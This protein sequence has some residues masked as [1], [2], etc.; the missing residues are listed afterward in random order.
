M[1]RLINCLARSFS[2]Y[3]VNEKGERITV[4]GIIL[5]VLKVLVAEH[6]PYRDFNVAQLR[7]IDAL[8][9]ILFMCKVRVKEDL[10]FHHYN[11]IT[12]NF[13]VVSPSLLW[14]SIPNFLLCRTS[15]IESL[16]T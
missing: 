12:I 4:I 3:C 9:K 2:R 5:S 14:S 11:T 1:E 16:R 10:L 15:H 7:D 8:D 13:I 6:Q